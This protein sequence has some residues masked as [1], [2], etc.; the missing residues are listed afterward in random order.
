MQKS[1]NKLQ[2][3]PFKYRALYSKGA[4]TCLSAFAPQDPHIG[5]GEPLYASHGVCP[6][7]YKIKTITKGGEMLIPHL[8]QLW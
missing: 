8:Q 3:Q 7:M 6:Y 2:V 5:R 1:S 4:A